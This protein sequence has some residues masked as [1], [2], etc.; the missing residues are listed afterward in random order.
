MA[1]EETQHE[2]LEARMICSAEVGGG[3]FLPGSISWSRTGQAVVV[4][5]AVVHI[6]VSPT[7]SRGL[8][9]FFLYQT[10]LP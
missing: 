7:F 2:H 10:E 1:I 9:I 6:F 3:A 5:D 8:F 4:L